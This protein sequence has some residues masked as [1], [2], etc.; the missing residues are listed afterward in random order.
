MSLKVKLRICTWILV[1]I[2]P[3]EVMVVKAP[4]VSQAIFFRATVGKGCGPTAYEKIRAC[5][6]IER[7]LIF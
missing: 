5:F 3:M 2:A 1:L 6:V 4:P 7:E